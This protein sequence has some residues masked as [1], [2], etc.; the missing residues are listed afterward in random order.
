[1]GAVGLESLHQ[2]VDDQD[3]QPKSTGT[4]RQYDVSEGLHGVLLNSGLVWFFIIA[5]VKPAKL[6]PL[7]N[8]GK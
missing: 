3:D 1:M 7:A 5:R 6:T 8:I 2:L 4:Q